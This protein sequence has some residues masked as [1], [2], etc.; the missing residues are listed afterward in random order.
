MRAHLDL[1]QF[2]QDLS[3]HM[4]TAV[5]DGEILKLVRNNHRVWGRNRTICAEGKILIC[6]FAYDRD[7]DD[8]VWQIDALSDEEFADRTKSNELLAKDEAFAEEASKSDITSAY[9]KLYANRAAFCNPKGMEYIRIVTQQDSVAVGHKEGTDAS[10]PIPVEIRLFLGG[11]MLPGDT[12]SWMI[13]NFF[14]L[15]RYVYYSSS[16]ETRAKA[17]KKKLVFEKQYPVVKH[18]GKLEGPYFIRVPENDDPDTFDIIRM[19]CPILGVTDNYIRDNLTQILRTLLHILSVNKD[20]QHYGVPVNA[21]KASSCTRKG[22][23][24]VV[25]FELKDRLRE[26]EQE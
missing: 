13:E 1:Q 3:F 21:L 16:A 7:L 17:M 25:T 15:I 12:L 24:L 19:I 14:P 2:T 20:F 4:R 26:L 8:Y 11:L 9:R 23:D 10:S 18:F 6:Y 5:K 22:K